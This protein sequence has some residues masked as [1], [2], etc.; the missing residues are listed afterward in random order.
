MTEQP[1]PG[2]NVGGAL[3][4]LAMMAVGVVLL[5]DQ[6]GIVAAL[7]WRHIWPSV[8]ISLG[9]ARLAF[10]REDGRRDGGWMVVIGTLLLMD[11]LRDGLLPMNLPMV[12]FDR[13]GRGYVEHTPLTRFWP[14][15]LPDR[16]EGEVPL[17]A[18]ATRDR[19]MGHLGI[20]ERTVAVTTVDPWDIA[21]HFVVTEARVI[22]P[23]AVATKENRG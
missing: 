17:D 21:M 2:L 11:Q 7:G 16:G 1:R 9:L 10:P 4:G 18:V 8:L 6:T 19:I 15:Y 14:L 20:R 23:T 5:L 22:G 12:L 13:R 3:V